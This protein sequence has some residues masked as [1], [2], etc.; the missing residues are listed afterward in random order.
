MSPLLIS[1]IVFLVLAGAAT[2]VY[3]SVNSGQHLMQGRMSQVGY[4]A[5]V[6]MAAAGMPVADDRQTTRALLKWAV[7]RL[8]KP[9][10]LRAVAPSVA[11]C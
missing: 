10:A 4:R 9:K 2:P 6:S 5:R 1:T 11:S 8:P 7:G 3:V